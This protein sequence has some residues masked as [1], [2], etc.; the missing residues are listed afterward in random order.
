MPSLPPMQAVALLA[1]L[2]VTALPVTAS[3]CR[4]QTPVDSAT[5]LVNRG[6]QQFAQTR[7]DSAAASFHAA[8]AILRARHDSA[9]VALTL[10]KLGLTFD[11]A[12]QPDSALAYYHAGLRIARALRDPARQAFLLSNIG[13]VHYEIGHSDS[14]LA[15]YRA[16]LPLARA[17]GDRQG[18]A[19]T[20]GGIGLLF[21][22]TGRSDSALSYLRAALPIQR[23]ISDR[24]GEAS[25]LGSIGLLYA[26]IGRPDSA[27]AYH[28]AALPIARALGDRRGEST[29]LANIGSALADVGLPDSALVYY[30]AALPLE[31]AARDRDGEANTLNNIGTLHERVGHP[32]SALAYYRAALPLLRAVGDRRV[33]AS[34][35]GNIGVEY[36]GL[37]Q[38]DSALAYFR[39]SLPLRRAVGDRHGEAATLQNIGAV[40]GQM[41]QPDS[42]VAYDLAALSLQRAIDDRPGMATTV[43]D[44]GTI[45]Q[46]TNHPD[47]ALTY[48]RVAL[49]LRRAIGDRNGEA[50]T[51]QC[52]G[53]AHRK[54]GRLD[55]ALAY[56]GVALSLAR[57][58][59]DP[60]V[61][62]RT[63]VGLAL[64]HSVRH[65]LDS[66]LADHRAALRLYRASG[67]RDDEANTLGNIG[68]VLSEMGRVDSALAVV[69]TALVL[70]TKSRLHAGNDASAV[71][72]AE[73][74]RGTAAL[75]V[76]L[77]LER[78][79]S[80]GAAGT[81]ALAAAERGRAQGLRDLL[82]RS[83]AAR[84]AT[85]TDA[86]WARDT[87]AGADLAREA[88]LELAPLA[89]SG[90]TV[91]YYFYSRD[92]L[93]TWLVP[94]A[95][96]PRLT[97]H[98]VT[99]D[100]L[101]RLILTL[102]AAL[103][104]D[105]AR[106]RMARGAPLEQEHSATDVRGVE[107][108]ASPEAPA[109]FRAATAA[110]GALLLPDAFARMVPAGGDLVI[111]PFD[112]LGY[113]PFAALPAPGDTVPLGIRYAVRYAPSLRALA[114]A[115]ARPANAA[116]RALVVGDPVMPT[117]AGVDG[118]R[119]ALRDLP[120]ARVE[121]DAVARQF[122]VA[123]L[124]GGVATETA[125]RQA[126]PSARLVHLA[127][128]GLAYGSAARVRDSYVALAPDGTNDGLLTIGE[129]LDD[130]P[131]LSA[132]LVVLSAC[133]TGLGDL[134]QAEGTVGFQRA[135]LA[136]GARSVLVSLWSVDDRATALLMQRFYAHWLGSDG[137][138]ARSKAEALRL[139]QRDV[140]LTPGFASPRYWAAFQ[141]VGAR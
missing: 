66:A 61:E 121:G 96:V 6:M 69:D 3:P 136:K 122:G 23:A 22:R 81:A 64:V 76:R 57:A 44:V 125:V 84:G 87:V 105:A 36:A 32:D 9:S 78:T 68:A 77:W 65:Q 16:S 70:F 109:R 100:S 101:G 120:A 92:T 116:A 110:L 117:V 141:L 14:A 11:D 74:A 72:Y 130:V 94:P 34:A 106:T 12:G 1:A 75:W 137:T 119:A 24:H 86:L 129:L 132:D 114:A 33:E 17:A 104:A 102:R 107:D 28:R 90:S 31:R 30:R 88:A 83:R 108:E 55:S 42:A 113:V 118:R 5:A 4:A 19:A 26:A 58:T 133:Q 45:L 135:L 71:A 103:G 50:A 115:E 52:I 20:L 27:L 128:H 97:R 140:R 73:Q 25:T 37:G 13:V 134:E 51:L 93:T 49:A 111:V 35:L 95:G 15:Y 54:L 60:R 139:A 85:P 10:N 39:A 7:Y 127:T 41:G 124:T 98:A 126:L 47:S 46:R 18:E 29:A 89:R 82:A 80:G 67:D 62:A 2:A 48:Y 91:L 53:D 56:Y 79:S 138:P 99:G 123:A 63:L 131:S 38:A 59:R 8:L 40:F 43:Q 112:A 21:A